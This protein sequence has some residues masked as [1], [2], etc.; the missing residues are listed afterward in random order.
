MRRIISILVLVLNFG[1]KSIL[2]PD[3]QNKWVLV[4]SAETGYFHGLHLA[5]HNNGWVVGDSG[6]V[7]HTNDGGKSWNLQETG[8]TVSLKCV[9]F[10]NLSKGW[11]GAGNNSI[12]ITTNGGDSWTWQHPTGESLRTFMAISFINEI[13]GW[14]VDNYG[15]ILHTED[16]GITWRPQTSG[17]RWA[18]TSI[19]FLDANEGWATATNRV[20]LHT[21]DGGNNWTTV[22]LDS[23]DCGKKVT[24]V[25]EDIFFVNRSKGWIA[26]TSAPSS[27]DYHPTP[28]VSTVDMGRTWSCQLTPEDMFVNAVTFANDQDGWGAASSGILYTNDGGSHWTYQ[29]QF[30]SALFVDICLVGQSCCWALSFTGNIYRYEIL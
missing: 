13:T 5:D 9:Y 29:L 26:T 7:L 27:T 20:V 22:T 2:E 11:I 3:S 24:V 10:S 16:G 4:R 15:G 14:I 17:T 21:T 6:R 23:L 30:P 25:F 18:I 8:T 1:C 12:G 19:Q 28:I